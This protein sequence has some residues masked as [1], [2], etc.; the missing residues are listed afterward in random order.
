LSDLCRSLL[1]KLKE[2]FFMSYQ[3]FETC[4]PNYLTLNYLL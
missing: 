2:S 4:R 3:N 1:I